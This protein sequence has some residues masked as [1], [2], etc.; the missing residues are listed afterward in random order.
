MNI[1]QT[2]TLE[3]SL[4]VTEE[5]RM[6][7][8][9]PDWYAAARDESTENERRQTTADFEYRTARLH[10]KAR[11]FL[12]VTADGPVTVLAPGAFEF[13]QHLMLRRCQAGRAHLRTPG[14]RRD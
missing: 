11:N 7:L 3:S 4:S 5:I 2:D 13:R 14:T 10:R 1:R 8:E 9:R 12:E 6:V